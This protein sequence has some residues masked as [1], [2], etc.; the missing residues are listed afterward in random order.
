MRPNR[1]F[2]LL[3]FFAI[4]AVFAWIM[5]SMAQETDYSG[6]YYIASNAIV[7]NSFIYNPSTPANNYYLCPTEEWCY[8]KP[9]NDFSGDG[10][11]YPNPFLTTYK[12][13]NGVYQ[14]NKALWIIT[15]DPN[16]NY[17]Y[18]KHKIDDK[19]LM[20]NG[21][22]R[23]TTNANRLRV[24]I[25]ERS[26][27]ND[28]AL[29]AITPHTYNNGNYF[30]ISPKLSSSNYLVVNG[31]NKDALKGVSGKGD[32]P[33][34]Y[35]Y[36]AG[37]IGIYNSINDATA[38][39]LLEEY[40]ARP[41]IT[42]NAA[43]NQVTITPAQSGASVKYTLDGSQPSAT[44]GED[45]VTS[46]ELP[47][48]ANTIKAVAIVG[49]EVSNV[50]TYSVLIQF[51]AS[52]TRL[53]QNQNNP[54]DT[55]Y[56]FYMIPG[57]EDENSVVKINTT[58]LFRPSMEWYFLDAGV[59]N[60]VQYYHIV[61]P[62]HNKYLCYDATN[63]L[64]LE[65][66]VSDDKFKFS[67]V[68][69][70]A[71]QGTFNIIPYG[72]S[73]SAKYINKK[74]G[75]ASAD[76][77]N[78]SDKLNDATARWK[79]VLPNSL[80]K[81]AP[82]T[83]SVTHNYSYHKIANVGNSSYFIIPPTGANNVVTTSNSSNSDI[84]RSMNW[85]F[86]EAQTNS[87]TD[88]NY[89]HI[90]NAITGYYLYFTK[91][92]NNDGPCLAMCSTLDTITSGNEER[93]LFTWARTASAG[94]YYIV[95]KRVKDVT[96]NNI[97][98]LQRSGGVI[99]NV[100]RGAG[101]NAWTFP[102]SN[103]NCDQPVITYDAVA[104]AYVIT[105]NEHNTDIYYVIGSGELT[106][107]S[108]TLYTTAVSVAELP[109][110]T[111]TIRAIAARN[112][113]GSDA[114]EEV[115]LTVNKVE[116]P[117][118]SLISGGRVELTCYT[119]GASI[120]YEIGTDP[121]IPTTSSQLYTAPIE[122]AAGQVIKAI[123]VKGGW[124]NS[125][126]A[127]FGPI[128]FT[129]AKPFIR[130]TSS[131]TFDI[132]CNYP[133][134]ATIYFTMG[135]NPATPAQIPANLYNGEVTATFP[136]TVK[137][138]ATAAGF[139]DSELATMLITEDLQSDT[140]G[141]YIIASSDDY[142]RFVVMANGT[143][144][145]A[146]YKITD[147]FTSSGADMIETP[148][149]GVLKGVAKP[150]GSLPVVNGLDHP[151]FNTVNGGT[152]KNVM[153]NNITISGGRNAGA[154]C[155][156][157]TGAS[158]I[159]NCGILA[160]NS[161][162]ISGSGSVGGLVGL[163]DDE[164]RVINCFSYATITGG[165]FVGGIVGNNN[166]ATNASSAD[167]LKTMVMNCMFYGDITGG[168]SRAPIYNGEMIT[169]VGANTGISNYN[170]FWSGASYV[171]D[172]THPIDNYNCALSAETRFLQRFEFFRHLLNGHRELAAWWATGNYNDKDEMLKWVMEPDSIGTNTPFPIL[173]A[174]G[175]H[176][177]VV[178]YA[179]SDVAFNGTIADR[180]KGRKLTAIG[181]NGVL[182][183]TIQMG[184]QGSAPFGAPEGAALKSGGSSTTV[185]LTITDKDTTHFNFNYGKVQLPY[186]ND[187]GTKNYTGN[188][189]VT[190]W[191]ITVAGGSNPY[192]EGD[193][194]TTNANGE[195]T[196]SPYN[197]AD[198]NSTEKD[199]FSN[200]GRIFNQG[201]YWDV[202]EGVTSITIEPYWAKAV[203][204]SD[205]YPD[206]VYNEAMSSA[207]NVPY[208]GGGKRYNNGNSYN[209]TMHSETNPISLKVY[210]TIG[211]AVNALNPS[212][213][214]YDNAIVL[215]GNTH[216]IGISSGASNKPYTIMSAD[217]DCDNEPDYSYILRFDNRVAVHPVRVDF[218]NI[219]GL[220]MAQKSTGGKGTY[221]FGI[222]SPLAWFESTN[223]S[224]F[225]VTQFEYDHASRL[226]APYIVQG[227]VI[228]QWVSG[229][230]ND[231][232]QNTTYFHVG[233]NVW[234]KEFHRGTH[235][236]KD[237]I[238]KHPPVSVTGGDYNEFY[239]TGLYTG[240]VESYDDN[241]E[242]YI[243]G[244]RF[245]IVAGAAM[246]GIGDAT[247]HTNGNIVWQ[248]Q[249][250]DVKE[251]YGGGINAA[252][253]VEGNITNVI[254]GGYIKLFCGG[255]KFGDM[256]TGRTVKTTATDCIFDRYFGAG[257]GGNSYNRYA[258]SNVF[259]IVGD[260]G[261]NHWNT[262]LNEQYNQE[263]SATNKG[264]SVKYATQY[265]PMSN[266]NTNV[267]RLFIDFVSFSL[268]T[269]YDITSTLTGCVI[270][271]NFYGGGNLGK[272]SGPVNSTLTD[273]TVNGNVFGAGYS[274]T[275][276][277]VA[278]TNTGNFVEAPFYDE[279]LG[280]YFEPK[281]PEAV[282]YTWEHRDETIN[283]T[284]LAIDKTNHILYTNV[285]FEGN[286]GL[287]TGNVALTIAGTCN[288]TGSVFGGGDEGPA[289]STNVT[290]YGGTIGDVYG[291]GN[292]ADIT[293]NGTNVNVHGG[294]INRVFAGNNAGGAITGNMLVTIDKQANNTT[295]LH[296]TELYGG[297]NAIEGPAGTIDI[298]CTGGDSEGI[299]TVFGG[300]NQANITT[301]INL[302]LSQ[303]RITNG[304]YGGNN[305][306]GIVKGD[307][308]IAIE[309]ASSCQY[310][311]PTV[312][313]GGY[314]ANT[315]SEGNVTVT[316]GTTTDSDPQP[317]IDGDVYGGSAF[318]IVNS[319]STDET[320]VN[321][322]GGAIS[323]TVYGGGLGEAGNSTKGTVNGVVTVNIGTGTADPTTGF[324]IS[325]EGQASI[326]GSVYGGNN[327][328]GSPQDNVFV[329]IWKVSAP[330]A[331]VFGGSNAADYAPENGSPSTTK[332]ARVHI[333][334]CDNIINRVF[335]GG[336]A[337]ASPSV[338]T[339]I[340]GG[341][342]DQVFG[343]GN[344][345]LGPAYGA[346]IN[347]TVELGIHGG[348]VGQFFG[349]S[350]QNGEISGTIS[351]VVDN[352][353]GCGSLMIDEF[354]CG[355][356]FVN[357]TGDLVTD[358]LC[359]EGMVVQDLY[360]GCNQANID[361]SVVLNVYGGT[362]TNVYGGSKGLKGDLT[363]NP[364]VA[365]NAANI[366]GSVTLNLYGGTMENVFGG[367]NENG[368][369]TGQI[370]VNVLDLMDTHCPLNITNIYGGSNL[371]DYIPTDPT[372][373]SPVVNV[374]HI[375]NGIGGNVYGGSKGI[376]GAATPNLLK[377]NP[378]V[379][380][381]YDHSMDTYLPNSSSYTV[382]SH[383]KVFVEG[384]VFGGGDAAQVEGNTII[385]IRNHTRV[386]GN[387]YGGGNLGEVNGN[388][389]VIMNGRNQ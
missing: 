328:G 253:P 173:K 290:V 178:N 313:G 159:Y 38:P 189:V 363:A 8:Y 305:T 123:A 368:N 105:S 77:L 112:I 244:G 374:V 218:I 254:T 116:M 379:N 174:P 309:G 292:N 259:S 238:S 271:D 120:Y 160:T 134:N 246:E 249:N 25:E 190:G 72:V 250:A 3:R 364:P 17:Y 264:V 88:C 31:G 336:N 372:I 280:V 5:P 86:E 124:I 353:S 102:E 64:H 19:Y 333:Y 138:I 326:G 339:F 155:N 236:D 319:A 90:R 198:R 291:G 216:N 323:G 245:G 322:Y 205:S 43:T 247:N 262:W 243:N 279:N 111:A 76:P 346:N 310:A 103:F 234:F 13:R 343:G 147:D 240:A 56:H 221:N 273:C 327:T 241:A 80:D 342:F 132:S 332:K 12:C 225:R 334:G 165:Y 115:S 87:S 317:A 110:E 82:F 54:W 95:P 376:F 318:G 389:K 67:I 101:T 311:F 65:D 11:T 365:P 388:T 177:S 156:D 209:F 113:D 149:T 122:N 235:I 288:I 267:A 215:V 294:T 263:Y 196:S 208:V 16:S 371:T 219:P 93:C 55:D 380:I 68:E 382:P 1:N 278:V 204:L 79:F 30:L 45:Y 201:A 133:S 369:I 75:N 162:T 78:L 153:L 381:G 135:D 97:S 21:Q 41:T 100:T 24:H 359:S 104:N 49:E 126:V 60:N 169:N 71:H 61:N 340:E 384:S 256:N 349:G 194:A 347:G 213:S 125:D 232:S 37:I 186:Y 377:A 272:V 344:G 248:I 385:Y 20:F 375:N 172:K 367:S 114:S 341:T 107:L 130:K 239:L 301:D 356:N 203:F 136:I 261:E 357:I 170:Y 308:T 48:G 324:S 109:G 202:P 35:T 230:V 161:S 270:N 96:L 150:D 231:V 164:S 217:F 370:V 26:V 23:T 285:V 128:T 166:Y 158:R 352:T 152:V 360:G 214:V 228:E 378:Q 167:N 143:A 14:A 99:T 298:Q 255:P 207:S 146:N 168:A 171:R 73:A 70:S 191:K 18:I 46:F 229:Q 354:F 362:Y 42:Y 32:G 200:S 300:A 63:A 260:W 351:V 330:I 7:S 335:G 4:L 50:A 220:G 179:S 58:S 141:F 331:N 53:I 233:G 266:N 127:T 242:C 144:S 175:K 52:H 265:L 295:D 303:G 2:F 181:D 293:T 283:S 281:M 57:D 355:G 321:I 306:A 373:T 287:V 252:N 154:I 312:Y 188:R 121:A 98:T 197:F 51:G 275:T 258:P 34:G 251:F 211:N 297:G 257:Y 6:T 314:G 47:D 15:K 106:P 131:N 227:G 286:L 383:P 145:G 296:I 44:V 69:S 195:I 28:S 348:S 274:A 223:T 337:A 157:A 118:L 282:T 151:I 27:L 62:T 29:F 9:Y 192:T 184:S 91:N 92:A 387:V 302:S 199:N 33:T 108:G 129:C 180:N 119:P 224:L 350:N 183:V 222:M 325:T 59:E 226:A 142:H 289:A 307:I 329:N 210:T 269:T 237:Y 94:Q 36:T 315:S 320:T 81:T 284:E 83:P 277:T 316:V 85:Y 10:T 84:V 182:H 137:A 40:I 338:E 163:L 206:V 176:P 361:G 193:D 66:Y 276:P 212:G 74:S 39:F 187:Y 358:I 386:F 299:G 89:Y 22:I 185:D 345:E 139:E 117:E 366:N 268:A 304:I 148:F 140:D